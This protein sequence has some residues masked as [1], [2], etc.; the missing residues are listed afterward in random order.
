MPKHARTLSDEQLQRLERNRATLRAALSGGQ[1]RKAS[2]MQSAPMHLTLERFVIDR[3]TGAAV[4][5][6]GARGVE[7]LLAE[8]AGTFGGS[9]LMED[10]RLVGMAGG[11]G[12][13][14]RGGG[15]APRGEHINPQKHGGP[16]F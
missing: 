7:R 4:P 3:D 8:L 2:S 9:R 14:G 11:G 10:G 13:A 6:E 5:F 12:H 16:A 1:R 15:G